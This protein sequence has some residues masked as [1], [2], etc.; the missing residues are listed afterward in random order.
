MEDLDNI[1]EIQDDWNFQGGKLNKSNP[2]VVIQIL[3][4]FEEKIQILKIFSSTEN[5]RRENFHYELPTVP[6]V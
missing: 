2:T 6:S 3:N 4:I 5:F 1:E